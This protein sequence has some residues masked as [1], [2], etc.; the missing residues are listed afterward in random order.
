[1]AI[2]S[3]ICLLSINSPLK[4]AISFPFFLAPFSKRSSPPPPVYPQG[5][6]SKPSP[7]YSNYFMPIPF[8]TKFHYRYLYLPTAPSLLPRLYDTIPSL[9]S[10]LYTTILYLYV[11]YFPSTLCLPLLLPTAVPSSFFLP[12][13]P[14]SKSTPFYSCPSISP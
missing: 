1:L 13:L 6:I 12:L 4:K 10:L 8:L 11:L 5:I 7:S 9:F 14:P 3:S 2:Y